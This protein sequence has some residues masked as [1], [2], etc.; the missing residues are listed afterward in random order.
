[1]ER[2]YT[3]EDLAKISRGNI[4]RVMREAEAVANGLRSERPPSLARIT[5][6]DG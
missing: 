2:G 5:E 1:M 4:L 6:L 3:E